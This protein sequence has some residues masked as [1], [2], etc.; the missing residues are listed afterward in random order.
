MGDLTTC[1]T[2][3]C[4]PVGPPA[5]RH[6]GR[7]A[8]QG[9]PERAARSHPRPGPGRGCRA[10]SAGL[11]YVGDSSSEA[12]LRLECNQLFSMHPFGS[13]STGMLIFVQVEAF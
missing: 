2:G 13:E 5:P 10:L 8:E 6:S 9:P 11:L 4:S 7:R 12:W 3:S 1:H